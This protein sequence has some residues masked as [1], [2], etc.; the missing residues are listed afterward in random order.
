MKSD[1]RQLFTPHVSVVQN[2][3]SLVPK[4]M[5]LYYLCHVIRLQTTH[6]RKCV[7]Q[8][9]HRELTTGNVSCNLITD[10]SLPKMCLAIRLQKTHYEKKNCVI[11]LQTTRCRKCVIQSDSRQLVTGSYCQKYVISD[12]RQ[13]ILEICHRQLG[14][15]QYL[16]EICN[17][18]CFLTVYLYLYMKMKL[19]EDKALERLYI[20]QNDSLVL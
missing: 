1:Y 20:T 3:C 13:F 11:R 16:Q 12:Y 15:G 7:M 14:C 8:S 9:D 10:N 19:L 18:M 2:I 5:S 17:A 6:Y 4:C